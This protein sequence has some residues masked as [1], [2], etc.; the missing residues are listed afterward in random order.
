MKTKKIPLPLQEAALQE[1]LLQLLRN[2][3]GDS[4]EYDQKIESLQKVQRTLYRKKK[5][6]KQYQ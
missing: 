2:G 1:E 4:L 3:K 5:N 6:L